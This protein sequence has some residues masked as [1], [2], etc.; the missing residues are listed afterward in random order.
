MNRAFDEYFDRRSNIIN[1]FEVLGEFVK[2]NGTKELC[3]RITKEVDKLK[4]DK[5]NL[6][7]VGEF[8]RGK[9]TFINA[10][11]GKEVLPSDS[12]PTTAII[13]KIKYN[14]IPKYYLKYNNIEQIQEIDNNIFGKIK[15]DNDKDKD[16][17]ELIK[18]DE[19][20]KNI[21]YAEIGFPSEFCKNDVILV[22]TPGVN[23]NCASRVDIT[24]KYLDKADAVI[25]VLAAN[26]TL[27]EHEIKFIKERV[28]SQQIKKIFFVLNKK[29]LVKNPGEEKEVSEKIVLDYCKEKLRE[30]LPID[31]QDDLVIYFV[32]SYQA[33]LY[34][35]R[36]NGERLSKFSERKCPKNFQITG[37]E[38]LED[39]LRKFLVFDK[40]KVKLNTHISKG[41]ECIRFLSDDLNKRYS[42]LQHLADDIREKYIA[43]E[44]EINKAS[45][46]S[47][48]IIS[49]LKI[50]LESQKSLIKNRCKE[51]CGDLSKYSKQAIDNY[52]GEIKADI[53]LPLVNNIVVEEQKK[54]INKMIVFQQ[55]IINVNAKNARDKLNKI[56][57]KLD[58]DYCASFNLPVAINTQATLIRLNID[59]DCVRTVNDNDRSVG[60]YALGGSIGAL[61]AGAVFPAFALG[62]FAAWC[63]GAFDTNRE[64]VKNDIKLQISKQISEIYDN[65]EKDV[66]NKYD[67]L[68]DSICKDIQEEIDSNIT[69]MKKQLDD[70]LIEK[71]KTE[72]E[73]EKQLNMIL[74]E[75]KELDDILCELNNLYIR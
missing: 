28:I 32:S 70:I 5:F 33:L 11:L 69:M 7:V 43:F 21:E 61:L 27:A 17:N 44:P 15:A 12:N 65:M 47:K 53:I 66:L 60:A 41:I 72:L 75:Q 16:I 37:F 1:C 71:N 51:V 26:Q 50:N 22:D 56:W 52:D 34:R 4:S 36:A 62:A 49:S 63:M 48:Q 54:F 3:E 42:L 19:N 2:R 68:V 18:I 6:L 30:Y 74:R 35:R 39:D 57:N 23:D 31:M 8:S 58:Q 64:K 29:D 38:E 67:L 59:D 10:L 24:Y 40:G 14:D 13:S 46:N 25:M 45:N 73:Q 55:E 9:S 20:I